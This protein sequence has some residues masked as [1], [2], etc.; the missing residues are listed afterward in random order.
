MRYING[1][2]VCLYVGLVG[3]ACSSQTSGQ[4]QGTPPAEVTWAKNATALTCQPNAGTI[5]A[6]D[7][8]TTAR[9]VCEAD[10]PFILQVVTADGRRQEVGL[11]F[12]ASELLWAPDSRSFFV[13]G[14]ENSYAGFFVDVYQFEDSGRVVKRTVTKSAQRDMVESFPPCKASNRDEKMCA[15]IARDP[16]YN[17]SGLGWS[18]DSSAVFV[19][20]EVPCS[21]S[22][23]GIMCQVLGYELSAPAGRILK[24]L[25]PQET[26]RKWGRLAAWEIDI[27]D[28]PEYGPRRN[29]VSR[30][31]R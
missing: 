9:V 15:R 20:A 21:S 10:K 17:M 16:E 25:T 12:G 14:S 13:N 27:P 7:R 22:Y 18:A 1:L 23:G 2:C 26:K 31:G 6:P 8:L 30:E 29:K 24:R 19:F 3:M 28:P 11:R 5:Q 4:S